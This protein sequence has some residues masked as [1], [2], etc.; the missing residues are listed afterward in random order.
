MA[1]LPSLHTY[2]PR[3]GGRCWCYPQVPQ[4]VGETRAR[5]LGRRRKPLGTPK[6]CRELPSSPVPVVLHRGWGSL[7]SWGLEIKLRAVHVFTTEWQP[8]NII[9]VKVENSLWHDIKTAECKR[10]FSPRTQPF[11]RPSSFPCKETKG[12]I[13]DELHCHFHPH[14]ERQPGKSF[15][16]S[17]MT[18][19]TDSHKLEITRV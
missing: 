9:N 12:L 17:M 16:S 10:G 15:T 6:A 13:P 5:L 2:T 1:L 8:P 7:V 4:Q 14:S 3:N 11:K 19:L 18:A